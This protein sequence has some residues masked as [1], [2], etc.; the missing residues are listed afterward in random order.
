[1]ERLIT[2]DEFCAITGVAKGTV[3]NNHNKGRYPFR[4]IGGGQK[5]RFKKADIEQWIE[6][7]CPYLPVRTS[8]Q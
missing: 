5:L 3:Y 4:I 2:V 7:G 8:G 1:M 6:D